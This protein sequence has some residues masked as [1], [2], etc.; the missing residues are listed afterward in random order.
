M[1]LLEYFVLFYALVLVFFHSYYMFLGII[2][3]VTKH[4]VCKDII[5]RKHFV[6]LIP[7]HNEER[8][9]HHTIQSLHELSYPKDKYSI[10]IIADNCE[11]KTAEIATQLKARCLIRKDENNRGKGQAL[12]W[13]F[14]QL[15][16]EKATDA[17]LIVDADT[18]VQPNL[19]HVL[20]CYLN[21]GHKVIQVYYDVLHPESSPSA[22]FAKLSFAISRNLKYLGRSRLGWTANLLGNGMCFSQEIIRDHGWKSYSITEDIEYQIYL[23][24]NNIRVTFAPEVKVFAEMPNKI[25]TSHTQR[26][27]W[28]T[29]KYKLRNTYCVKLFLKGLKERRLIYWDALLELTIPP[30]TVYVGS[31]IFGYLTYCLLFFQKN[32]FH[33]YVW[34]YL[35][36]GISI[37]CS[38]GFILSRP[39]LK[40]LLNLLYSPL[41]MVSRIFIFF[42]SLFTDE[43]KWVKTKRH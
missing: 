10:V 32:T 8:V 4:K 21:E 35:I 41:F 42:K 14:Q 9:I 37:Y 33:Y 24:M 36:I 5:P 23:L 34:T 12:D 13:A 3:L 40:E 1:I 2:G 18:I 43:K 17:Y 16:Q 39:S 30:F 19:L 11:D 20:N 28:D 27:R 26:S 25:Q 6:I 22:S 7:A 31:I 29:G 15:I 38:V